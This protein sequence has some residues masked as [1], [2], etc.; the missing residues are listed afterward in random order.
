MGDIENAT[1]DEGADVVDND[2]DTQDE[3][4]TEDDADTSQNTDADDVVDADDDSDGGNTNDDSDGDTA[5][6]DDDDDSE[7]N[8]DDTT[9]SDTADD[10]DDDGEDEPELRKPNADASNAEWAAWRKQEKAKKG[11]GSDDGDSSAEDDDE[12]LSPE[13][14]AAIDKRIAKAVEP[15]QKKAAEQEVDTEIATFLEKN[16][17]FK[18][19][20]SKVRRW[21]M[22]PNRQNVPVKAIFY[23]VAGDKLMA[24]GAKRSKVADAKARKTKTGGGNPQSGDGGSKSYKDMS[25]DDFGKELDAEK[26]RSVSGR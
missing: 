9:G 19:Y 12:D 13:D 26:I 14:A 8:S 2:V 16:P 17:D 18:P 1:Q 21:A 4:K 25:L 3:G 6:G 11:K 22:H 10:I 24:I 23:E 20:S 5:E 7:G 15:F